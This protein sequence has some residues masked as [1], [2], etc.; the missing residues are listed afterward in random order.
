MLKSYSRTIRFLCRHFKYVV[1]TGYGGPAYFDLLQRTM[2]GVIRDYLAV[3]AM[4]G[5]PRRSRA[6]SLRLVED[7]RRM[8]PEFRS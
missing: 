5:S 2:A 1:R 7:L 6:S 8:R 3:F 4:R